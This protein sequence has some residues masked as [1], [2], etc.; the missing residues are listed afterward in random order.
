MCYILQTHS[1][2][3]A[4]VF[5]NVSGGGGQFDAVAQADS[6]PLGLTELWDGDTVHFARLTAFIHHYLLTESQAPII[7][8]QETE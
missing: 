3:E 6:P 8:Q 5:V 7:L 1:I 2:F 4:I